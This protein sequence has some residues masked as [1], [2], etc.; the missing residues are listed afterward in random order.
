MRLVFDANVLIAAFVARGVCAE[1]LEHCVREHEPISSSAI[2]EETRRNPV[3]K[4]K[5]T[6]ADA[7]HAV[8]L[9]RT[10]MEVVEPAALEGQ[11]CRDADDDMVLGTAVA[12][13]AVAIVTGDRDLLDL[14]VFREIRILSPRAFWSFEGRRRPAG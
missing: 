5:V 14:G 12:G 8:K 13:R 7:D 1:L 9:L 4:V 6:R 3:S 11:V 2:L 10:R